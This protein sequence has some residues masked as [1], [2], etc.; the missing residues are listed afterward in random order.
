MLSMAN[1]KIVSFIVSIARSRYIG[2]FLWHLNTLRHCI[3]ASSAEEV[4]GLIPEN[5]AN[6]H[7][8]GSENGEIPGIQSV[9]IQKIA[10]FQWEKQ[11]D[12]H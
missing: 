3:F 11:A 5:S 9:Y 4:L 10:A 12:K 1:H 2:E 7:L 8:D 6:T